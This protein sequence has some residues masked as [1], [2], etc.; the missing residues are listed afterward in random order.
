MRRNFNKWNWKDKLFLLVVQAYQKKTKRFHKRECHV[1]MTK[2][3]EFPYIEMSRDNAM[4]KK[5]AYNNN[6]V[7]LLNHSLSFFFRN[8]SVHSATSLLSRSPKA[9]NTTA[10]M[11]KLTCTDYVDFGKCQDRFGQFSWSKN[12]SYYLDEKLIEF[13]RE[14]KNAE[15]RLRRNL[16]LGEADSNQFIR[17]RN[18]LVIA[19]DNFLR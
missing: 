18:Q 17:Q 4:A 10:S 14:Q 12:D 8:F 13:K 11:D 19:A 2:K 5:D 16:T 15:I 3:E 6:E 7:Q 9:Y 1:T